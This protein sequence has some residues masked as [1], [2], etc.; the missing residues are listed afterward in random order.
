MK[1]HAA[2]KC[3]GHVGE[4]IF[5]Q[6][7]KVCFLF[8]RQILPSG[9]RLGA[10]TTSHHKSNFNFHNVKSSSIFLVLLFFFLLLNSVGSFR[11]ISALTGYFRP[12]LKSRLDIFS[13]HE[14]RN[15][16]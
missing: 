12:S 16:S 3:G 13:S 11:Y 6:G 10:K 1:N 14:M 4:D 8:S 15:K 9:D 7:S 5:S 2:V